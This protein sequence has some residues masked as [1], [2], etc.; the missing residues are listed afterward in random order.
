MTKIVGYISDFR[1][2]KGIA[3]Y[4]KLTRFQRIKQSVFHWFSLLG[5][6]WPRLT[7]L[8]PFRRH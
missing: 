6:R 3:R 7:T 2:T 4:K 5:F 8:A 1:V